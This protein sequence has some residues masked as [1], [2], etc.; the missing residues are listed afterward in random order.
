MVRRF[1]FVLSVSTLALIQAC[2]SNTEV[3]NDSTD[4]A[5]IPAPQ[6]LNPLSG[7]FELTPDLR[8]TAPDQLEFE[9]A[10]T[11]ELLSL[12]VSDTSSS[13][14]KEIKLLLSDTITHPEGYLL[15]ISPRMVEIA[16]NSAKGIFYGLQTL[17]QLIQTDTLST[18]KNTYLP[19]VEIWDAPRFPYRGMH[20]DVGRHFFGVDFIKK[21]L[22]L[23]ALHKMNTFHW[24]LTEDQGWRIEIKKYPK[25]TEIGSVRKE[26]MAGKNFD[27]YVGDGKPYGGY[28]TQDEIKE[29]VAYAAERHITVIPEIEMPGHSLAALAAYPELG[30]GTGP[31]KVATTW[32][33]FPQ[34]YAPSERTFTFLEDVLTEIM[35][36]FP[37]E[38]IHIG[39]DEAPKAEW[40]SGKIAREVIQREG[41]KDAHELQ[42]YFIKRIERFLNAN[43]RQI[44]GW[45]EILEGG[46]APNATVMSWRGT[47]GG[48]AAARQKHP[49]IMTPTSHCYFDYYQN[50]QESQPLA[51]GGYLPLEKVYSFE[52]VPSEL[53]SEEAR[54]I[55]GAQG[56]VWTEYM[57]S[58]DQVTYMALPRMSALS[59]V[60][61]TQPEKKSWTSFKTRLESLFRQF[62]TMGVRYAK[63]VDAPLQN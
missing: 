32:G 45:D 52:P 60:V 18:E 23:I 55:K 44:I 46:L 1:F 57:K 21:Y 35:E 56:N 19:S 20:L 15:R 24:H 37:S 54:F 40:E 53:S 22:D 31:Y 48:I 34:I 51:I 39:G 7:T 6:Y 27:P 36:L 49:V 4:Y 16:G 8:V 42:S 30:N 28:Y 58:E 33:V 29:V 3:S 9:K 26:T 38:Y 61:W 5:V 25:L 43:G 63:E 59:E 2:S 50:D 12:E 17:R 41:L 62:D 47:E 11:Q 13:E 10:Y 14:G